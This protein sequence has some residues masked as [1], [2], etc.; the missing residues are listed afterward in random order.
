[1]STENCAFCN[2]KKRDWSEG[3]YFGYKCGSCSQSKTA[4]IV[5]EDH[6]G[7]LNDEEKKIVEKLCEKHYPELRIKWLSDKRKNITHWY[8]FLAQ[9]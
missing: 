1:M 2:P 3:G 8:D 4:F 6:K 9:G 5:R 7:N